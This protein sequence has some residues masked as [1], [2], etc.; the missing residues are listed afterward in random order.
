MI[1]A[2]VL[3]SSPP[4]LTCAVSPPMGVPARASKGRRVATVYPASAFDRQYGT[5][6]L[7]RDP[8]W[9]TPALLVRPDSPSGKQLAE[10]CYERRCL[11]K[12]SGLHEGWLCV[13]A[14]PF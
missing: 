13:R 9:T 3:M 5:S 11:C 8:G 10:Q 6:W 4:P 2:D 1:R 7:L 14:Y 12:S